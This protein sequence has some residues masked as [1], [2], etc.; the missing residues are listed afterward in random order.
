VAVALRRRAGPATVAAVELRIVHEIAAALERVE[1][2]VLEPRL[3]ERMPAFAPAIVEAR[4]LSR[5]AD[6]AV[7]ER[8]AF[9]RAGALPGA[10]TALVPGLWTT[11]IERTRWDLRAHA[12]SFVVEPQLPEA[13]RRRV[14]CGGCYSLE[15][16]GPGRTRRAVVGELRIEAP[17]IGRRA[18]VVI[19]RVIAA[20]F[21]G[22]A[23]LLA[24][25]A[26]DPG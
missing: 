16:R 25:L 17:V 15:A 24:A 12:A 14:V 18:E 26:G 13:L 22:E 1:A 4:E 2:A 20:Q 11:W 7:V 3:L 19:G 10:L 23:A 21:A 9:F 8:V 5:R 6:E